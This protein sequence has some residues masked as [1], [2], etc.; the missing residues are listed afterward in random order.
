M[1]LK[2][3]GKDGSMGLKHGKVYPVKIESHPYGSAIYVQWEVGKGIKR[4]CPYSSPV[5]L[6]KNWEVAEDGK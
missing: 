3:I 4:A 5:T 1:E 6:A 2:F